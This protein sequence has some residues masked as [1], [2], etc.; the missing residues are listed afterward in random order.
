[1][2][3]LSVLMPALNSETT[4][5]RAVTSTLNAL[6]KDSELVVLDD[7]STD[8][9][10]RALSRFNDSRL[11]HLTGSHSGVAAGLNQLLAATDSEFVARMDADDVCFR[12]RLSR[13]LRSMNSQVDVC[14]TTVF[15]FGPGNFNWSPQLPRSIDSASFP[16][17]LLLTNPVAHPTMMAKRSILDSVGG[18]RVLPTEDYD[19]W[20]RLAAHGAQ[21]V[22]LAAPGI[23]YRKHASQ[24][25]AS[26]EWRLSSWKNVEI[27]NAYSALAEKILGTSYDRLP[28]LAI[29]SDL[30]DVTFERTILEF[31][32]AFATAI[33]RFPPRTQGLLERKCSARV[34]WAVGHRARNQ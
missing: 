10:S 4:I 21:M 16:Y 18:Y 19:L 32:Q 28:R 25:T 13:Q 17:H 20:L 7:G 24:V 11:S 3:R 27:A 1:M 26:P 22:R 34:N 30:S 14:F 23:A 31:K 33:M 9:T 15:E 5:T 29:N 8:E 6:P 12:S 2:P